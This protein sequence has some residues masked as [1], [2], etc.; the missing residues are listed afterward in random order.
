MTDHV[1]ISQNVASSFGGGVLPFL[2]LFVGLLWPNPDASDWVR[3]VSNSLAAGV[4]ALICWALVGFL[5]DKK[6]GH[7]WLN[8][9]ALS[10]FGLRV[11]IHIWV[12]VDKLSGVP[13][14]PVMMTT[15]SNFAEVV[16]GLF[17]YVTRKDLQIT[18]R[19]SEQLRQANIRRL[20]NVGQ[21]ALNL[22]WI[23]HAQSERSCQL[24]RIIENVGRGS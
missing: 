19:R 11:V 16:F 10:Y 6:S 7:R 13:H 23:T 1:P 17:Y 22:Q 8:M 9:L 4:S 5:Q 15:L 18:Y 2:I 14:V 21:A 24:T 3:I 12:V 20:D